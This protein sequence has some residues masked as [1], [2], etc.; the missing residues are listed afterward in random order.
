MVALVMETNEIIITIIAKT[1]TTPPST[2]QTPYAYKNIKYKFNVCMRKICEMIMCAQ[3]ESVA[4][5][6]H[7]PHPH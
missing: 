7:T 2:N 1:S 3:S 5:V 4:T 6:A